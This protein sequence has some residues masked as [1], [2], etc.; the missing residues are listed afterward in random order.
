MKILKIVVILF[1]LLFVGVILITAPISANKSGFVILTQNKSE[2]NSYFESGKMKQEKINEINSQIKN[3]PEQLFELFG[4]DTINIYITF[5]DGSV[6]EYWAVTEKNKLKE[7]YTG[8]NTSAN[9]EIKLR[10]LTVDR[11]VNSKNPLQRFLSAMNSGEIEYN[12][13]DNE[14][15]LKELTVSVTTGVMGFFTGAIGF[16]A[17]LFS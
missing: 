14:G 15:K 9:V 17:E 11:I 4:G 7:L 3:V 16:V 6:E 12:G 10:E 1:V 8:I 5:D 13:L 2:I